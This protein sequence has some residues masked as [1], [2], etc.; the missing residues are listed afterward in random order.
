ML[1]TYKIPLRRLP[2]PCPLQCNTD[3][4]LQLWPKNDLAISMCVNEFDKIHT[5]VNFI[6]VYIL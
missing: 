5:S 6:E 2:A 1:V 4:E 3:I